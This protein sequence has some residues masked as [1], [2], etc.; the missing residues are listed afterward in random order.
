LPIVAA[1]HE[2]WTPELAIGHLD[3]K[4]FIDPAGIEIGSVFCASSLAGHVES[5]AGMEPDGFVFV[6]P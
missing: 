5:I 3:F 6:A 2:R 4:G 1:P